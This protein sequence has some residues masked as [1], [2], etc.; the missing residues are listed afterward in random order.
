VALRKTLPVSWDDPPALAVGLE[1]VVPSMACCARLRSRT[2]RVPG[3]S[4]RPGKRSPGPFSDPSPPAVAWRGKP[5]RLSAARSAAMDIEHRLTS[6]KSRQTNG[7]PERFGG[8][9]GEVVQSHPLRP[10][11]KPK[12]TL[13]RQVWLCNQPLPQ[14]TLGSK[15]ALR[16]MTD[17][18]QLIPKRFRKQSNDLP[19]CETQGTLT[20]WQAAVL[21][22]PSRAAHQEGALDFQPFFKQRLPSN[23][24]ICTAFNAAPL[25]R[26]SDTHQRFRPFSMVLSCRMR[27]M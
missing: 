22:A 5:A 12:T 13:H 20:R 27:L 15:T 9:I 26:L 2:P 7:M 16:T 3:R 10:S 6:L 17:L 18:Q 24:A 4:L 14:S 21:C 11:D 8:G 1:P 25:R 23:S 19:G